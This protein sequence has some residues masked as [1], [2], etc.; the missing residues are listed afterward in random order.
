MGQSV[1]VFRTFLACMLIALSAARLWDNVMEPSCHPD[2]TVCKFHVELEH[3]YTMVLTQDYLPDYENGIWIPIRATNGSENLWFVFEED[4]DY[5]M[6]PLTAKE[7]EL[8]ITMDGSYRRVIAVNNSIPGPPLVVYKGQEVQFSVHNK[9]LS[10]ATTMHFHGLHM[11]GTPW[12][13]GTQDISQCPILPGETFTYRF[14]ADTVGT[15]WYHSHYADQMG[16]GV[17]GAIV[18]LE[19]PAAVARASN[20]EPEYA[21]EFIAVVSDWRGDITDSLFE[22]LSYT[23]LYQRCFEKSFYTERNCYSRPL[24]PDGTLIAPFEFETGVING[25]GWHFMP[26]E[27]GK[28]MD[29]NV[30]LETFVV[31]E[32]GVYKYRMICSSGMFGFRVSVDHHLLTVTAM[33]GHDVEAFE[34]NY[35]TIFPGERF[36]FYIT[37]DQPAGKYWFRMETLEFWH[38][39]RDGPY[40]QIDPHRAFA[41]VSY[42]DP[43]GEWPR[44]HPVTVDWKCTQDNPCTVLNCAYKDYPY[45]MNMKCVHFT[46]M[47]ATQE[48]Q[49]NNAK[50]IDHMDNNENVYEHFLLIGTGQNDELELP[51]AFGINGIDNILPSKPVQIYLDQAEADFTEC[52]PDKSNLQ[53]TQCSHVVEFPLHSTVQLI[54]QYPGI[55]GSKVFQTEDYLTG[56]SHPFHIHGFTPQVVGVGFPT[57]DTSGPILETNNDI[58]N[59]GGVIVNGQWANASWANGNYPNY[60]GPQAPFK[61]TYM[62]PLGGYI[63][64]RFQADNPGYWLFHCHTLTHTVGGQSMILKIGD[65]SDMPAAPESMQRCGDFEVSD[66]EFYQAVGSNL[67]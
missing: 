31:E 30:P 63:I 47:R 55:G 37:A 66:E 19:N 46:E 27:G 53:K 38:K 22:S 8:V 50:L 5:N 11:R 58:D 56:S 10:A 60:L 45:W 32:G 39:N 40:Q 28:V 42:G 64:L 26:N 16:D 43:T 14:I 6:R 7:N 13:D 35:I 36:D 33:D 4:H 1:V 29:D 57:Y 15:Y 20:P 65:T 2:E 24:Q 12:M 52:S 34:T 21:A 59:F 51:N 44:T 25:K 67:K 62:V 48:V 17:Q 54:V 3:M 23:H 61:D 41:V 49:D 18:V 9:L